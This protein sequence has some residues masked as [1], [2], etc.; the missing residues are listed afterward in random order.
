MKLYATGPIWCHHIAHQKMIK[1][2]NP[3]NVALANNISMQYN[4]L[5]YSTS[6]R[7]HLGT[8]QKSKILVPPLGV[9]VKNGYPPRVPEAFQ[10]SRG[11]SRKRGIQGGGEISRKGYFALFCFFF[12][13]CKKWIP[14]SS[15]PLQNIHTP[16]SP[17]QKPC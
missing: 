1:D 14:P 2:S 17:P 4:L 16:I 5:Y 3:I 10:G 11:E 7:L 15:A 9:A 13:V 8:V 6:N 12:C